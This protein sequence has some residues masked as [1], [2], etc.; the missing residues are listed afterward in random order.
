MSKSAKGTLENPG[1]NVKAKSGLNKS[2]LDQGWSMFASM[3][4]YKQRMLGGEVLYVPAPYTSQTCPKCNHRSQGN[5][6]S[7]KCFK[8]EACGYKN[9]ADHVGAMNILARGHR[10]LACGEHALASSKKQ[11]PKV[12]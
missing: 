10:V 11:E 8:C 3:L 5:R 12:A 7:Q 1:K 9:N 2:I 6:K 4:E